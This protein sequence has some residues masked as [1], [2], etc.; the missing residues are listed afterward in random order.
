MSESDQIQPF[1]PPVSQKWEYKIL[2]HPLRPDEKTLNALGEDGWELCGFHAEHTH[3]G[4]G[5]RIS[6]VFKRPKS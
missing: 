6:A 4:F 2:H 1:P 3:N 5:P